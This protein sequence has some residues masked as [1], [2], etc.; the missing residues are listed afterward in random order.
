MPV[1]DLVVNIL[2]GQN[3]LSSTLREL[4]ALATKTEVAIAKIQT[5]G[6]GPKSGLGAFG[7]RELFPEFEKIGG[8]QK[9]INKV[10]AESNAQWR[11]APALIDSIKTKLEAAAMKGEKMAQM[12]RRFNMNALSFLFAGMA[13]QRMAQSIYRFLI[14]S[15]D[16]LVELNTIGAKKVLGVAAAFEFLKISLFETLSQTEFFGRFV[17]WLVKGAIAI[18]EFTQK[19]PKIVEMVAKFGILMGLLG[20]TW[21]VGSAIYQI[22][23]GVGTF[24]AF[25]TAVG[26]YFGATGAGG[27]VGGAFTG[28]ANILK[29]G[30]AFY[31]LYEGIKDAATGNVWGLVMD[32][33]AL[34]GLI[35]GAGPYVIPVYLLLKFAMKPLSN[36]LR[37]VLGIDEKENEEI[38]IANENYAQFLNTLE[39]GTGVHKEL[40]ETTG[41]TT[42]SFD[43]LR[44]SVNM[45]TG[46]LPFMTNNVILL[47]DALTSI[48]RYVDTTIRV[49]RE[50]GGEV[51]P[52][53]SGGRGFEWVGGKIQPVGYSNSMTD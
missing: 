30:F 3:T 31:I 51:A 13:M 24:G 14:P 36:W 49:H 6:L 41:Q 39:A 42:Q 32:F 29:G 10:T 17:E 19:H 15:M 47:R 38:R 16:K 9:L 37:E 8:A 21:V 52:E 48:P 43:W 18:S 27:S 4:A 25:I 34:I 53:P 45:N 46:A 12:A 7:V 5:L 26:T 2:A 20:T 40:T 22:A 33:A 44:D 35:L 23:Y 11:R 28:F 1:E 50:G